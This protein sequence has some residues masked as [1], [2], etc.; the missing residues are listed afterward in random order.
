MITAAIKVDPEMVLAWAGYGGAVQRGDGKVRESAGNPILSNI[1]HN[2]V[3]STWSGGAR[4]LLGHNRDRL[5]CYIA[6]SFT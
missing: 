5:V 1:R 6:N 3:I 2:R 4:V